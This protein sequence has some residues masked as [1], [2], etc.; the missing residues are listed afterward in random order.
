V[1]AGDKNK[2]ISS[3]ALFGL[4]R[5]LIVNGSIFCD[6]LPEFLSAADEVFSSESSRLDAALDEIRDVLKKYLS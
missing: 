3:A 6:M 4:L 1:Y 5:K 2:Y